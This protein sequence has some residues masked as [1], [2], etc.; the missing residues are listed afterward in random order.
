MDRSS[1]S[2]TTR[3]ARGCSRRPRRCGSK[4]RH[5]SLVRR[6]PY[7]L[8]NPLAATTDRRVPSYARDTEGRRDMK[9][10]MVR[11]TVRP[12]VVAENERDVRKV[13]EQLKDRKP[14]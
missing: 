4:R 1:V 10:M 13:F 2:S 9:T 8:V 12:E 5:V 3:T 11:Y 7:Y 14:G 6:E